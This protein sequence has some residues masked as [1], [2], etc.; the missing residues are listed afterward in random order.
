MSNGNCIFESRTNYGGSTIQTA[1]TNAVV[2]GSLWLRL[3][4]RGNAIT[5]YQSA[6]GISWTYVAAVTNNISN[7]TMGSSVFAGVAV[8]SDSTGSLNTATIGSLNIPAAQVIQTVADPSGVVLTGPWVSQNTGDNGGTGGYYGSEYLSDNKVNKGQC[9][10]Q[11]IPTIPSA[12]YYDVYMEWLGVAHAASNTPV[13]INY[14][15]GSTQVLVNEQHE[16]GEW[17]YIGTFPFAAGT[18]GNVVISNPSSTAG[19][20]VI[21]NAVRFIPG[22]ST[23]PAQPTV[24]AVPTGLTITRTPGKAQVSLLWNASAGATSYNVKRGTTSGGP[25]TTIASGVLVNSPYYTDSNVVAGVNYYYVVTA[26]NNTIAGTPPGQES[27]FS[28]ETTGMPSIISDN[29]D[30]TGVTIIGSWTAATTTVGYYGSN[31][32]QDGG[33]GGGKS[34]R[35]SPTLPSG[36]VYDVYLRWTSDV[37]RATNAPVDVIFNGTTNTVYLN[38]QVSDGVWWV[39][40]GT[41]NFTMGTNNGVVVRDDGA[42]GTVIADAVEFVADSQKALSVSQTTNGAVFSMPSIGGSNYQLQ[43]SAT[44]SPASW[45]N[46]GAMQVGTDEPLNFTDPNGSTGASGFYRVQVTP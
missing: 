46:V 45:Q 5:A 13:T 30:S 28:N 16:G 39:Y 27:L 21:A 40:L 3:Y 10:A 24:P 8:S 2:T 34:V 18:S 44:L 12:A 41:Y 11:F 36:G 4:R 15:G 33:A 29:A 14:Q 42:N 1:S 22:T 35:F 31:Y 17:V 32:L 26:V 6:D 19:Y 20:G 37:N 7:G 38:Q 9:S 25:Y 23:P 43:K